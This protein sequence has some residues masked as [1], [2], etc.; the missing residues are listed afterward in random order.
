MRTLK[1]LLPGRFGW[2][3]TGLKARTVDILSL[4]CPGTGP[5]CVLSTL[6][7]GHQRKGEGPVLPA[8]Q[9][10]LM[11]S[12]PYAF[13]HPTAMGIEAPKPCAPSLR[14]LSWLQHK[15]VFLLCE[16]SEDP[17]DSC[18]AGEASL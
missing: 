2:M 1:E 15:A 6:S 18:L 13:P 9:L 16:C 17:F 12:V 3:D 10:I 5:M 4:R 8:P 7:Q 14:L 11:P